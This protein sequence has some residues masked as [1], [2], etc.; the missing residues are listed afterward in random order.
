MNF[1]ISKSR[2]VLIL[3]ILCLV[4]TYISEMENDKYETDVKNVIE[5]VKSIDEKTELRPHRDTFRLAIASLPNSVQ[6]V[7]SL[8]RLMLNPEFSK[9]YN[10]VIAGVLLLIG[11]VSLTAVTKECENDKNKEMV[12]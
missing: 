4:I 7:K 6:N 3:I 9:I 1:N 10:K 8:N 2:R 12:R 5:I 11:L